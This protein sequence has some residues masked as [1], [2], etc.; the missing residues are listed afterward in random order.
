MYVCTISA[1]S[2]RTEPKVADTNPILRLPFTEGRLGNS[3]GKE[4]Y[5]ELEKL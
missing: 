3:A 2:A 5:N 1:T 4:Q